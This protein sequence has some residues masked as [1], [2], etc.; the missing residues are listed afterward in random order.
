[1]TKI[2]RYEFTADSEDRMELKIISG[3]R[4]GCRPLHPKNQCRKHSNRTG[5]EYDTEGLDQTGM[6]VWSPLP[7][8]AMQLFGLIG[9]Q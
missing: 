4:D 7:A 6:F 2:N 1:M 5:P 9:Q 3:T 8:V